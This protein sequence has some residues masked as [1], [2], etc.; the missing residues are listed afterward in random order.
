MVPNVANSLDESD[1]APRRGIQLP[2][3][4]TTFQ[5]PTRRLQR[6]RPV[7][8]I[9]I[10]KNDVPL[11]EPAGLGRRA[12]RIGFLG[13]FGRSKSYKST[14][15]ELAAK[16]VEEDCKRDAQ[17][18]EEAN[19]KGVRTEASRPAIEGPYLAQNIDIVPGAQR[20]MA[21]P[22]R[23]RSAKKAT[24]SKSIKIES[25]TW[26]PPPLFQAYPQAI[27]HSSLLAPS[28]S[29]EAI[30]RHSCTKKS[31]GTVSTM[32][33]TEYDVGENNMD[34]GRKDRNA[35][36]RQRSHE[37]IFNGPWVPKIYILVTSGYMLQYAGEGTFD[38]L[39]EKILSLGQDSAAFA[40]DAIPGKPYVVR[41][42][43]EA[44]DNDDMH[45][46]QSSSSR[47]KKL[48]FRN[49][50]R[51]SV[52]DFLLVVENPEEMSDWLVVARKEIEALGGKQ[53]RPDTAIR[54]TSSEIRRTLREKPSRRFLVKRDP[55]QFTGRPWDSTVSSPSDSAPRDSASGNAN[56]RPSSA[57]RKSI[58][59]P[60][61]V[62][63][64]TSIEQDHL[65]RLRETPRMS[66][67]SNAKT[68][69][70]SPASSPT[71]SPI[72][73]SF[74]V[75]GSA[76]REVCFDTA[77]LPKSQRMSANLI[78]SPPTSQR[79]SSDGSNSRPAS[80]SRPTSN[81]SRRGSEE[82][83][84]PATHLSEQSYSK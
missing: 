57:T 51:R 33:N 50:G 17:G 26:D 2:P 42:C 37:A 68:L 7:Q 9:P 15:S 16:I 62:N 5:E 44:P 39:P 30:L 11:Q 43:Q 67:A 61:V 3:I 1:L 83:Y 60:S 78:S 20:P 58:D 64:L 72:R 63:T 76:N 29:A 49:E 46:P 40:S 69:S 74:P 73:S 45:G 14:R 66:Y 79:Q 65:E 6:P 70:T 19:Q 48:N 81:S 18:G 52:S 35:R 22:D 80:N 8:T 23:Q 21:P 84:P 4:K 41:I 75:M 27:K 31:K 10:E 59:S 82:R 77:V 28:A 25:T 34:L 24:R 71:H 56:R 55:N 53:Y 12:S 47:F 54:R 38:R 13:L 32:A 36:K